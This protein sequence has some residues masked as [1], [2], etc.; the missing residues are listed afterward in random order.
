LVLWYLGIP[1]IGGIIVL[2]FYV[3]IRGGILSINAQPGDL[4]YFGIAAISVIAGLLATEGTKKRDIFSTLFGT[5][6]NRE[7]EEEIIQE[8]KQQIQQ[9]EEKIGKVEE[10]IKEKDDGDTEKE[11]S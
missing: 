11:K 8:A 2:I 10:K 5:I 1:I 4:N 9:A 7:K 3:I 6:E